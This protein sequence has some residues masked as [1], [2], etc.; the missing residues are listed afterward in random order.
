MEIVIRNSG[1]L[2]QVQQVLYSIAPE[3]NEHPYVCKIDR[4]FKKR[5]L[6][7][8]AY[9]HA[10]CDEIARETQRTLDEVKIELNTTYG[11]L[12]TDEDGQTLWVMLPEKAK[13]EKYY[14]YA[15]WYKEAEMN[16]KKFNYYLLYKPT[17]ELNSKEMARLID[18]T[19]E[20]AKQLGIQTKTQSELAELA[21]YEREN[22]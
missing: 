18:G 20:E 11:T 21:G 2:L 8:N 19:I 5:S 4:W 12:A 13:I 6:D 1:D 3:I 7:A 22:K 9:F 16:G 14:D 17:H 15:K 10:L